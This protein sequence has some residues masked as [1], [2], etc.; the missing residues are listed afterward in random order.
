MYQVYDPEIAKKEVSD[1]LDRVR[2]GLTTLR[3]ST[4][5]AG[6]PR[7]S[8]V[9]ASGGIKGTS[10]DQ[11]TLYTSLGSTVIILS[12]QGDLKLS[13]LDLEKHFSAMQR[14][15]SIQLDKLSS[16]GYDKDH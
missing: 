13:E 6:L 2:N 1:S 9:A 16:A 8:W 10:S 7:Q 14:L 11:I 3:V 15:A 12:E 5:L 4:P